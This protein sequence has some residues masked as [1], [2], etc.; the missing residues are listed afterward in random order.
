MLGSRGVCSILPPVRPVRET[1]SEAHL[2]C[3]RN[4]PSLEDILQAPKNN[5]KVQ[6]PSSQNVDIIIA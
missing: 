6:D 3:E 2:A 5:L 1:R 4:K